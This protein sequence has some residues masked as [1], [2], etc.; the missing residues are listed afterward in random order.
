MLSSAL[1]ALDGTVIATAA[2]SIVDDVGGLAQFPWL[3]TSYLLAQAVL[4]PVCGRL[5]DMFGR[6]PVMLVGIAVFLVGSLLCALAWSMPAL[7]A[8]RAVQGIGV[9]AL[10]PMGVTIVGDLYSVAER[11]KVQG[12][13]ASVWGASSVLGP[14]FG[15]GV[16]EFFGWRWIFL[17]N[18]PLC[19]VAAWVLL[20]QFHERFERVRRHVDYRGAFLIATGCAALFL[21]LLQGDQSW[22]WGSVSTL[23]MLSAGLL[24]LLFVLLERRVADPI[25]PL[26]VF[27]RRLLLATNVASA[28]VGAIVLGLTTYIPTFVNATAGVGPITAGLTLAALLVGWPIAT[29]QAGRLYLRVGFRS[30][31]LAGAG[32]V[33]AGAALLLLVGESTPVPQVAASC[34]VVGLGLGLITS[35]SLVAAQSSVGWS[36]RGAVTATYMFCR[37]LGSAGGVALL[38]ALANAVL[39][40]G[41]H[42]AADDPAVVATATHHVLIAVF[43]IAT[44]LAAAVVSMPP[45]HGRRADTHA[46]RPLGIGDSDP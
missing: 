11:A 30:C 13:V 31:A 4:V 27:S 1:V 18:I 44:V 21:G 46:A 3:F 25:V 43:A 22:D 14:T 12:Y 42:N 2:P 35:P 38:G 33:L 6:K 32:L 16:C 28:A 37:S 23:S 5:A 20:R 19:C 7:I 10:Q 45:A 24:I 36:D 8:F 40:R 34:F 26:W 41:S 15:G 29:S 17:A 9:G 39:T